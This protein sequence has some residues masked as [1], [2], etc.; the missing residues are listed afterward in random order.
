MAA[1]ALILARRLHPPRQEEADDLCSRKRGAEHLIH[2]AKAPA[3]GENVVDDDRERGRR[4]GSGR[5]RGIG[6]PKA[7]CET[8]SIGL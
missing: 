5:K 1:R 3:V 6:L 7:G 2:R 4:R 8:I